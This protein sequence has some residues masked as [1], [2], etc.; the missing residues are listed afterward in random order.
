MNKLDTD[1]SCKNDGIM[2]RVTKLYV[3]RPRF[4]SSS[5]KPFAVVIDDIN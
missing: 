1:S 4:S 5:Q 3:I 2:I